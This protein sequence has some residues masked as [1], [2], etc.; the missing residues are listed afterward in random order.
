MTRAGERLAGRII[1]GNGDY[2]SSVE[3]TL[4]FAEALFATPGA[5]P[6]HGGVLGVDELLRSHEI[7]PALERRGIRV[8]VL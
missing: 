3:A 7:L 8:S 2:R 6:Q 5:Q 1:M 4:V